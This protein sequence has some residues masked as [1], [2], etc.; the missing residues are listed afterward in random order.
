MAARPATVYLLR[1]VPAGLWGHQDHRLLLGGPVLF[2]AE[3]VAGVVPVL[4]V[5]SQ[6][7]SSGQGLLVLEGARMAERG[8]TPEEIAA[9][10]V[11]L[12]ERVDASFILDRLDYMKKGGRCSAV[13]A[14]GA[15]LLQIKPCT[16][17]SAIPLARIRWIIII[18]SPM[19]YS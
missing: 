15:N 4:V 1:R 18:Y 11:V 19:I 8:V 9:R 5:D 6:S 3:E 13:T 12:R 10:L 2:A 16:V 17:R 7:L 14:M